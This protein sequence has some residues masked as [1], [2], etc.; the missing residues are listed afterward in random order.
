MTTLFLKT[1]K[2]LICIFWWSKNWEPP[3]PKKVHLNSWFE[4]IPI[5]NKKICT[6]SSTYEGVTELEAKPDKKVTTLPDFIV[7]ITPTRCLNFKKS[8]EWKNHH[9]L[10][11]VDVCFEAKCNFGPKSFKA[12][13]EITHPV[14][15]WKSLFFT[16]FYEVSNL[17]FTKSHMSGDDISH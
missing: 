7:P 12:G 16:F 9:F 3:S 1:Q 8:Q 13:D 17:V 15:P 11:P 2:K 4:D 10:Y 6:V 5:E 14:C